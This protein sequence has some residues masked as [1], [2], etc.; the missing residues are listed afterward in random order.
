MKSFQPMST[1]FSCTSDISIGPMLMSSWSGSHVSSKSGAEMGLGLLRTFLICS[2][3][4]FFCSTS[5]KSEWL[6]GLIKER[7]KGDYARLGKMLKEIEAQIIFSGILPVP[8][9]G[10]QRFSL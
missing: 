4:P 2:A 1:I 5:V 10:Q 3:P 8:R 7:I 9:E 6:T